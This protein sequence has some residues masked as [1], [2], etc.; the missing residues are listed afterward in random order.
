MKYAWIIV[1]TVVVIAILIV[2]MYS[3]VFENQFHL[4]NAAPEVSIGYPSDDSSVVRLVMI[5]GTAHDPD[6][7]SQIS[8]VEVTAMAERVR[9]EV[10]K[11]PDFL[12]EAKRQIC[13]N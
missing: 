6:G 9:T 11:V 1:T 5:S 12:S 7:D 8:S 4:L 3:G 13:Y 10:V 2:A